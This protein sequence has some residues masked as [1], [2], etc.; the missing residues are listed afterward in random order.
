VGSALADGWLG[1]TEPIEV[2]DEAS[3]SI[4][5]ETTRATAS[6]AGLENADVEAIV[7]A[8]SELAYNHLRH[9]RYGR[10][11]IRTVRR[12]GVD[13]VE[14]VAADEGE[15]IADPTA[16]FEGG[17]PDVKGLGAGLSG[18]YRLADEVDTDIRLGE[19]TCIAARKFAGPVLRR[20]VAIMGRPHPD[21]RVSGDDA[22]VLHTES[23]L[24]LLVA[25]GLGHGPL[26]REGSQRLCASFRAAD[27]AASVSDVISR[28]NGALTGTRGAVASVV[29]LGAREIVHAG[30]G[31]ITTQL[32]GNDVVQHRRFVT[33]SAVVGRPPHRTKTRTESVPTPTPA[34]LMMWSDGLASRAGLEDIVVFRRPALIVAHAM[35]ERFA[36][37]TDD[38]IVLV[39]R[40]GR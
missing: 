26:A 11:V 33:Q 14:V 12:D 36:R 16:A 9:A 25:D 22:A 1:E 24:R 37:D 8:A 28:A 5:R 35:L 23:T 3:V 39:A 4:V 19:G 17:S 6:D 30:I 38:A 34:T 27:P 7:I 10:V 13:G 29:E 15:G 2:L 32:Q 20:E 40:W 31:N 18:A 21:E